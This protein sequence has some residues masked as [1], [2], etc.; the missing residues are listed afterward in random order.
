MMP[1][2][3]NRQIASGTAAAKRHRP[4][5]VMT[6]A[7]V[8]RTA[9]VIQPTLHGSISLYRRTAAFPLRSHTADNKLNACALAQIAP[10]RRRMP[11]ARRIASRL[12]VKLR[13]RPEAPVHGAEGVQFLRARGANQ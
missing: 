3:A 5:T 9:K 4:G 6:K 10:R 12:T 13:G 1:L 11:A 7:M 2:P 8:N